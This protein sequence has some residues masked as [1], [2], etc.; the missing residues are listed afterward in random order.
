MYRG[1]L[2]LFLF[3]R[4]SILRLTIKA[5]FNVTQL[6]LVIQK[7]AQSLAKITASVPE[8]STLLD[9]APAQ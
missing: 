5:L 8:T 1:L 4:H 9:F 3:E 6:S 7:R 2:L